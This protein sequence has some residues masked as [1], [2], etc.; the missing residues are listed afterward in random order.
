[1]RYGF[2]I[3]LCI[4]LLAGHVLWGQTE[5]A[6]LSGTIRDASS[7]VIQ[8]A[9]VSALN[10]QTGVRSQ[11]TSN[12]AG[13]YALPFLVPGIYELVVEK[14]GFRP[15]TQTGIRLD[16]SDVARIDVGLEVGPVSSK[17]TVTAEAPLMQNSSSSVEQLM[18]ARMLTELPLASRQ[19]L[20]LIRSS[21]GLVYMGLNSNN[22]ALFSMAGGRVLNQMFW[23]DGGN[24]QNTRIG[25]GQNEYDPPAEFLQEFRVLQSTY[26]AEYGATA[27]GVIVT[28]TKSGTNNFHGS[29]YEFFRNDKLDAAGPRA[30]ID[31]SGNKVKAPLRYNLFGGTVGGPIIRNRTHFYFG[32]QRT[33]T[34]AGS[35]QVLTVPSLSQRQGDFSQTFNANGMLIPIYDPFSTQTVDGRAV[36]TP[37]A[38][39][40]IPDNR[41]DP[42]AMA[43]VN[44]WPQP[45]KA[46]VNRA[47]AQNFSGNIAQYSPWNDILA[48]V[49]HSF[50]DSNHFYFRYVFGDRGFHNSSVYPDP[51][52]DPNNLYRVRRPE[53]HVLFSDTHTFTPRLVLDIRYAGSNRT[54]EVHGAGYGSN[55]VQKIGLE[56]VPADGFPDLSIAGIQA[57]GRSRN[58]FNYPIP[59]HQVVGSLTVVHGNHLFKMGGEIRTQKTGMSNVTDSSG[60]YA[61]TTTGSGLPGSAQTG[62]GFASFL[63][64]W[65]NS[66]GLT[67]PSDLDRSLNYLAAFIQDD[68]K[69]SQDLT[70]NLGLRWETDTP[71]RD[72]NDMMNGFDPA[73]INPVSG[74]PG[75]VRFAGVNGWRRLPYDTNL[76]NFGPRIGFA[77]TP[78]G[79]KTMVVRGGYGIYFEHPF[80]GDVTN[81]ATLGFVSSSSITS[82]DN[83]ITPAFTLRSGITIPSTT[84]TLTDA[85]GAVPVGSRTT[86]AVTFFE[87]NRHTGYAQQLNLGIQ[88]QLGASMLLEVSYMGSLSRHMP[89]S[90]LTLNQVPPELMGPGN[91]QSRRPYPQFSGVTMLVP[92]M[93]VTNYH[94]GMVRLE[95][96]MSNGLTVTT[97]YTWSRNIGDLNE[98]TGFGDNQNYQD[99]YNRRADKGPSTIDIPHRFTWSSVYDLPVGKSRRWLNKGPLATAFGGWTLGVVTSVQ[100]GGPF[101][102]TM[103]TDTTNAFPA[104]ALRANVLE[105][106]NLSSGG[107]TLSRWFNTDAF[108]A[109]APYTFG[110][111]GR[112]IVR[113]PRQVLFDSSIHKNFAWRERV[114][115]QVR[116]DFLNFFNHSNLGTPGHVMGSSSFGVTNPAGSRVVQ[117]G[118]RVV[119]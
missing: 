101:T 42:V 24:I 47:G 48:R 25:I 72:N 51:V 46:P 119:F 58:T 9:R 106:A 71:F 8:G 90:N 15:Y 96:R 112:G 50:S 5:R 114:N 49:D 97:S 64:G 84:Q 33:Q 31:A 19:T 109:P 14:E 53:Y 94:A 62:F 103:Q 99:F 27:S 76:K 12:E 110:N 20:D 54:N 91:A 70:L 66:F 43:L 13:A 16:V 37:F 105:D 74:T 10:S 115:V 30:P 40:V 75:V 78:F 59:Q 22:K 44:Y 7:A 36:R 111:A 81:S 98:N 69:L 17:V 60:T 82:P 79:S 88:R 116:G 100:S 34:T 117:L 18:P 3:T 87:P 92:T 41:L 1:V 67:A 61:F 77:W 108:Q 63:L 107:R 113:S 85:F 35:T 4:L 73:A 28:T 23:M 80:D 118:M 11:T 2:L 6:R 93:G 39:N 83:G 65:G 56:G 89:I 29:L 95:K 32:Y 57:L 55:V 45:N 104:G 86:T 68:W 52:A 38:G 102:V 26:T 21:G